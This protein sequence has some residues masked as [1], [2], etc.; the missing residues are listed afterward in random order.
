[1]RCVLVSVTT[2][3]ILVLAL[4]GC[5][6]VV[7]PL[8]TP[9]PAPTQVETVG[10]GL[11]V[12]GSLDGIL[13]KRAGAGGTVPLQAGQSVH[14]GDSLL[15]STSAAAPLAELRGE[16]GVSI[17]IGPGTRLQIELISPTTNPSKIRLV[18]EDGAVVAVAEKP[19]GEGFL[20]VKTS[21]GLAAIRGSAMAVSV[22]ADQT[23]V[24]CI[25]D[26][27]SLS[28]AQATVVLPAGYKSSVS[29]NSANSDPTPAEKYENELAQKDPLLWNVISDR[30][31]HVGFNPSPTP[32]LRRSDTPVPTWT[33]GPTS[34]ATWTP[35]VVGP[36]Q[37]A[38][39]SGVI[40]TRRPTT[41]SVPGASGPTV[42]E[43]ANQGLHTYGVVCQS[44]NK[45]VCDSANASPVVEMLITF[46][47]DS[48]NL[49]DKEGKNSLV[50][51][52][53]AP[54]LY[55]VSTTK[56]IAEIT[57]LV[58][59]WEFWVTQGGNVCQLQTFTKIK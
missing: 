38:R 5:A 22:H 8:P 52:R 11:T 4:A 42:E 34:A 6:A 33:P 16:E 43:L 19:L 51:A 21:S 23:T 29:P 3:S 25:E 58:G 46:A 2:A 30:W 55:A 53:Q 37:T 28:G 54:N 39:V 17:L 45:C 49:S 24:A 10:R 59:G 18:L 50:Y 9:A 20:Q 7:T 36:T 32:D 12:S 27:A 41:T 44:W 40:P 47:S 31:Y 48:A 1:M 35:F 14:A 56:N 57:F 26:S 13:I 15:S